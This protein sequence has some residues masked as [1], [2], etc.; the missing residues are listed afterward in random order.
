MLIYPRATNGSTAPTRQGEV[1]RPTGEHH[2]KAGSHATGHKPGRDLRKPRK[3]TTMR[4]K[5]GVH[6]GN[7]GLLVD[8]I[9]ITVV[10]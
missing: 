2:S 1:L 4:L 3:I 10:Y 5:F 7:V 9:P 8:V 6:P